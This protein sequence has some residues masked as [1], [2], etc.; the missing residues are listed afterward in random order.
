MSLRGLTYRCECKG[1]GA[2]FESDHPRRNACTDNCK[3]LVRQ[4]RYQRGRE[5]EQATNA[6]YKRRERAR[7]NERERLRKA[8]IRDEAHPQFVERVDRDVVYVMHGGRCGI[9]WQFVARDDFEIDHR[10]PLS[11][12]GLHGYVNVQ[13]S[14]PPCNRRKY[15]RLEAST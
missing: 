10:V 5:R 6:A 8:G 13:P 7:C 3:R 15:N 12:G 11:R 14:H 9:C 1:C 2:I 4:A